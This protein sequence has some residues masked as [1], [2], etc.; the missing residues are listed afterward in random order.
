MVKALI[1]GGGVA[2]AVTAVALRRAGIS[3]V[4]YE[5]YPTGADDIGAFLTIMNNGMDALR[6]VD[7]HQPVIDVAFPATAVELRNSD[8][9]VLGR[10]PT[11]GYTVK[12]AELYRA[13]HNAMDVPLEHGKRLTTAE[14]A[15]DGVRA[16]FA[17]GTTAEADFLVGA[18]GIHSVTRRIIDPSAP[19]PR[20]TGLTVA[21]GYTRATSFEPSAE[22]Y[23][24]VSG[25][26]A[27]FG[28]T[29]APWG[30]TWWFSRAPHTP[31]PTK[32]Y[33]LA[34]LAD[35]RTPAAEIIESTEDVTFQQAYD[36][37]ETPGWHNNRLVLVGDAAHAA[38]PAAGQGASMA[39]EDSVILAKC[40]RDVPGI[41]SAFETY[42]RIRRPRVEAL[43]AASSRQGTGAGRRTAEAP[44]ERQWVREH[45]ID[46]ESPVN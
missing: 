15:A 8:F 9:D 24:M 44:S 1:I 37:P 17:D 42:T 30:E 18:D 13:L 3:S 45:H 12:R 5:A 38:S 19:E 29:T 16:T 26:R 35:D 41:T 32:A 6:A 14:V 22:A 43:V 4:V 39:I 11:A 2:G 20:Y 40:L 25:S 10:N 33:F 28:Y 27:M 21:Y 34:Q 36:V 31:T 7:L 23:R 46:W